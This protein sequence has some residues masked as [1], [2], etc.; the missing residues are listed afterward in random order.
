MKS[1][2]AALT[3]EMF[4]RGKWTMLGAFLAANALPILLITALKHEGPID[5]EDRSFI[6][7]HA[8]MVLLNA[9]LFGAALFEAMGNPSRLYAFPAT[10][11][12]IVAWQFL[13]A[14]AAMALECVLTT[15]AL[16][17]LFK[18]NWPIWGPALFMPVAMAISVACFRGTEKS[19]WY[20][21]VLGTISLPVVLGWFYSRYGLFVYSQ[22]TQMW[23]H[24]VTAT[25]VATMSAMAGVAYCV[26]VWGVAR[27]RCGEFLKTPEVFRW[28]ARVLDP[29]PAVGL[30]FRSPAE[31]QFWF[32]WRQK[33]WAIPG[34]VVVA[35]PIGFLLW[36][37]FN[38]NPHELFSVVFGAGGFLT[39][40]GL[41][42]GLI[43]GHAGLADGKLEMGHFLAT[44]PMTSTVM[45]RTMLKAA[46]INLFLA[47]ALWAVAFLA[48]YAILLLAHVDPRPQ[49]PSEVGWWYFPIT[50][51]GTWIGLALF[52][53]LGQTGRSSL[54][55]ILFGSVPAIAI[56]VM[57]FA[58][59]VLSPA[60]RLQF[61]RWL[62]AA[63]GV[64]F[65]LGTVWAFIAARRR[66][67]IGSPTVWAAMVLWG[68]L[69]ALAM[70]FCSQ[71]R[72]EHL[73]SPAPVFVQLIGLSALVV[74][75]LAAAP[76]A[77]VWNRNR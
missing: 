76:L 12:V 60:E 31:A 57:L 51:L 23:W 49:L 29:A 55:V 10:A 69:C 43:F 58:N 35:L 32:E 61:D 44:R 14:M 74:F 6:A 20:T 30:P 25:D 75:P 4:Q 19:P 22:S 2:P 45:A 18:L 33:G 26:A 64:I 77:L 67:L 9:M 62:A 47:W 37:I 3:W 28:L 68:T 48:L 34:L 56:G 1:I 53:T 66:S 42:A 71:H 39:V 21:F 17:A 52:A 41:I 7:I 65:I 70:L 5:S 72:N 11:S 46:G 8:A 27:S 73:L 38:R 40:V 13:P 15:A 50:L 63:L 36:L 59:W 54:I 16:D 24:E